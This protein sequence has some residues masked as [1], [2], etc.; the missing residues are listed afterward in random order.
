[1]Y[2]P[3]E[4]M[5]KLKT[6]S[7]KYVRIYSWLHFPLYGALA[8]SMVAKRNI[9]L[10]PSDICSDKK[11]VF[12]V[13]HQG[14]PDFFVVFFGMPGELHRLLGPYRFFIANRF[15][16][17]PFLGWM[18]RS[19]GGF[20]AKKHSKYNWG[21]PAAKQAM[22]RGEAVVIFPEGKVSLVERRYAPLR[23]VEVLAQGPD[24]LIIPAR[25]KW[26]R[27]PKVINGYKLAIGKPFDAHG[28]KANQ[29]MDRVYSLKF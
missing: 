28:M 23:G 24:V 12:A 20:P 29:I 18:L 27:N 15:F 7:T 25:V 3:N 26:F 9:M 21:I 19:F 1:M 10:Q 2:T 17:N 13:N 4:N 22:A 16:I 8:R 14:Q 5:Q 6:Y 11:Y